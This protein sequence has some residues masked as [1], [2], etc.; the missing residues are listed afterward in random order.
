MPVLTVVA[1]VLLVSCVGR[2]STLPAVVD[3][4]PP[5]DALTTMMAP[6][7]AEADVPA[8]DVVVYGASSAGVGA[9]IGAARHGR[10]VLL[11]EPTDR[12]GGM[13]T[14]GVTTDIAR[15]EAASGLF[16]EYLTLVAE[17]YRRT[18]DADVSHDGLYAEPDVSLAAIGTLLDAEPTIEVRKG[19]RLATDDPADGPV[20]GPVDGLVELDG[21]ALVAVRFTDGEHETTVTGSVFVDATAEGDLLG[22]AGERDVDWVLGREAS[23]TYGEEAAPE[24]ADTL[25]QA[26]NYRM[27]VQIGG[28]TDFEVPDTYSRDLARY[29]RIDQAHDPKYACTLDVDGDDRLYDGARIQRCLPNGKMDLNVDLIGHNHTYVLDGPAARAAT[30]QRLRDFALGYLHYLRTERGWTELGLPLDDFVDTGGFP[31]SL[32]VREGRRML[33]VEVF[34]AAHATP[35]H[36]GVVRPPAVASS[37]AIGDYGMDAHCVGPMGGVSSIDQPCEGGFWN[38]VAPYQ[39]PYEV[40]VP[41]RLDRLLVPVAVSASHVGYSTLRMEPVRMSLGYAAGVAA[42][43]AIEN[44]V[45]VRD[46]DV[47]DLQRRLVDDGHALLFTT[48]LSPG[49]DHFRGTQLAAVTDPGSVDLDTLDRDELADVGPASAGRAR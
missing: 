49:T 39:V 46:L 24:R 12:V 33:G 34:T 38:R 16:L 27:T 3:E 43:L 22:V 23:A 42:A 45:E 13:I 25:V 36:P 37:I 2:T 44:D 48:D 8:Y 31:S 40:L 17:H 19:W 26:Y 29:R 32:Y 6:Q 47:T 20:D 10:R 18:G 30:E 21:L 14:N 15:R 7:V 4:A 5:A 9:A 41:R 35:A 28:R 11:V 1:A